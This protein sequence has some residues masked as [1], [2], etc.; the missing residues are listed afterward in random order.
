MKDVT[1]KELE[2]N[3]PSVDVITCIEHSL[4]MLYK[5]KTKSVFDEVVKGLTFEEL[6]GTLLLSRDEFDF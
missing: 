4:K 3:R 1:K 5:D 6:I 2:L